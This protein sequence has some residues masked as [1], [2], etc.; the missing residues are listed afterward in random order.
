GVRSCDLAAMRIQDQVFLEQ[1]YQDENYQARRDALFTVVVN[2]SHP[3]ATCFCASTGDG[4]TASS[5]YDLLLTE[6]DDGFLL[7]AGSAAGERVFAR[8]P[9]EQVSDQQHFMAGEQALQAAQVQTRKLPQTGLAE[10]LLANLDHPRWQAVAER[11]LSCGNCTMVCPTCFCHKETEQP[12]LDGQSSE[13]LREWDSC[14]TRGHSYIH[15]TVIR[16]DTEKRYRQWLSHKLATWLQQFG[17][18]GC[19]G[20]GRCISWCP[21]GIDL[22]EEANAIAGTENG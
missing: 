11:C 7:T 5:G 13:H 18:S 21:A 4:P 17:N 20:C 6:L 10:K 15:G 1:Q 16:D 12:Q 3:A 22:T 9:L 8:L 19:V 2:C 14:F